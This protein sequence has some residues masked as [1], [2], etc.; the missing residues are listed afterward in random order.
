[1]AMSTSN[2]VASLKSSRVIINFNY[3]SRFVIVIV[4]RDELVSKTTGMYVG[5]NT[6][7]TMSVIE[8]ITR[9]L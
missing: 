9:V 4:K 5:Y 6:I 3:Y 7:R 1:M 2:S 8:W